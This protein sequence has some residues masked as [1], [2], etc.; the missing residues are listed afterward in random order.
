MGEKVKPICYI[1]GGFLP[2]FNIEVVRDITSEDFVICADGGLE[3]AINCGIK[4]N[5]IIGDFDSY[6][7][8]LPGDVETITLPIEKDDTD[9]HFAAKEG[10]KRG[11]S[12]FVLSG[13]TGG[14]IDMTYASFGTLFYL[15]KKGKCAVIKDKSAYFYITD[16]SITLK[17]PKNNCHLSIFPMCGQAKGVRVLGAEYNTD[18]LDI[19]ADFPIGVSNSFKE[20][21]V[22]ISVKEGTI[23]IMVV[24]KD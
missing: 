2:E 15:F 10:I 12:H 11:F 3:S 8:L 19:T 7:G 9:L 6:K 24:S 20:D 5:L 4:P 21:E 17:K 22:L 23:L 14:R 18:N 13:V 1:F 16:S